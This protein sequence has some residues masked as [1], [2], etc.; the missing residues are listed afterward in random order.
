MQ[1]IGQGLTSTGHRVTS[2]LLHGSNFILLAP[3]QIGPRSAEVSQ[4]S[5]TTITCLNV[6][7][8]PKYLQCSKEF[9]FMIRHL[10]LLSLLLPANAEPAE[11]NL[12]EIQAYSSHSIYDFPVLGTNGSSLFPMRPCHGIQLEEATIDD[13]Q[14][15][16]SSEKLTTVQL[17]HCYL[18]RIFQTDSYLK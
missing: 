13:L 18:D 8:G 5:W 6:K 9:A 1:A 10:T 14:E 7:A 4:N 15:Y 16:L 3:Q 17:L 11:H 2:N 12:L